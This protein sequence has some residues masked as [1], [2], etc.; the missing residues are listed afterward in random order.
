[1][2]EEEERSCSDH[3][4]LTLRPRPPAWMGPVCCLGLFFRQF[5][6]EANKNFKNAPPPPPRRSPLKYSS[7]TELRVREN[8]GRISRGGGVDP[9]DLIKQ[10]RKE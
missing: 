6:E 3:R 4:R 2:E 8:N 5:G 10:S 1:M 9:I 7:P